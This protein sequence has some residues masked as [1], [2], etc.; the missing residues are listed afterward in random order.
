MLPAKRA[1]QPHA[2]EQDRQKRLSE[3][4]R[5]NLF[6]RKQQ[7]RSRQQITAINTADLKIKDKEN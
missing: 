6:K 7:S 1:K 5:K 4:L 3:A 2:A